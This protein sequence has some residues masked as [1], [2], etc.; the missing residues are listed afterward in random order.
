MISIFMYHQV[1]KFAPMKTH[2]ASYCDVEMFRYHMRALKFYGVKVLSIAEMVEVIR[3]NKSAP[4][5]SAVL[6]FDDGCANFIENALPILEEFGYPSIVYAVAGLIGG[7]G[8]WLAASDHPAPDLMTFEQLRQIKARGVDVGSHAYSH[9]RLAELPY[10]AQLEE[11][12][13]SKAIL[14]DGLGS[15]VEHVCYPYGSYN[16]ETLDAACKAGYVTGMTCERAAAKAGHDLLGLPRK[17][18]S[19][20]DNFFGFSWKLFFKNE[21]KTPL[22]Q[23]E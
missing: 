15:V 12:E 23:R 22:L 16:L 13:K 19:Y 20:G 17:A 6:T 1:G 10:E 2:R 21:P 4:A 3:G 5:R 18:I 8:D 7:R 14:E 9:A 11:L